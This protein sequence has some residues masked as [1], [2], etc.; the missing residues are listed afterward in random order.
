[1]TDGVTHRSNCRSQPLLTDPEVSIR[2]ADSPV[3]K[4][5]GSKSLKR[6]FPAGETEATKS[7]HHR[8]RHVLDLALPARRIFLIS[9]HGRACGAWILL[10]WVPLGLAQRSLLGEQ[11][12]RPAAR[13]PG[14]SGGTKDT[15]GRRARHTGPF[16]PMQ[17]C[18]ST[19]RPALFEMTGMC[20]LFAPDA[21]SIQADS[22]HAWR[23]V[24]R[25]S[26]R[27]MYRSAPTASW[28]G[29][30]TRRPPRCDSAV[31]PQLSPGATRSWRW[32]GLC[33]YEELGQG[34]IEGVHAAR[35][36]SRA[37]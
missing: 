36:P 31:L 13:P 21:K 17:I 23:V 29:E 25:H 12:R 32:Y 33:L 4:R 1:M 7:K 20:H 11:A 9:T 22:V 30:R 37:R 34:E 3:E 16:S 19:L 24:R 28:F 35:P 2:R 5:C 6:R 26:A 27:V 14:R 15:G 8:R 10:V 18:A